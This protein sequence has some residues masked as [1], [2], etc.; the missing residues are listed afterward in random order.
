[1]RLIQQGS[2]P[3][4]KAEHAVGVSVSRPELYHLEVQDNAAG[5]TFRS[6]RDRPASVQLQGKSVHHNHQGAQRWFFY[7]PKGTKR[8]DYYPGT[9]WRTIKLLV[10]TTKQLPRSFTMARLRRS[11]SRQVSTERSGV[12]VI[13]AI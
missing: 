5:W 7:V 6:Q 12:L 3:Q 4:D 13:R 8:F 10:L 11:K 9:I 2:L 1:M